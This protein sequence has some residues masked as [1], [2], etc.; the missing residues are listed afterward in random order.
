MA[1]IKSWPRFLM[2]LLSSHEAYGCIEE[3]TEH[4]INGDL[5]GL[6]FEQR[7]AVWR[8]LNFLRALVDL[9][10]FLPLAAMLI[11]LAG[12]PVHFYLVY[13]RLRMPP[14]YRKE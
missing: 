14:R 9:V 8:P 1:K 13:K 6:T 10:L 7:E 12:Y 5:W 3:G 11:L 4:R 2:H